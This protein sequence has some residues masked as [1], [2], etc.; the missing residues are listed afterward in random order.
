MIFLHSERLNKRRAPSSAFKLDSKVPKEQGINSE[1]AR[2]KQDSTED[3]TEETDEWGLA[4][5][6]FKR[7]NKRIAPNSAFKLADKVLE[8]QEISSE[9]AC[10]EQDQAHPEKGLSRTR[11]RKKPKGNWLPYS[12]TLMRDSTGEERRAA[13]SNLRREELQ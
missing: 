8:E 5:L 2:P 9:K 12:Y 1:K 10:P 4:F 11:L 3:T 13:H 7:L 6:N